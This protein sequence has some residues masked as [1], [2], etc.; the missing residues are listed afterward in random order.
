MIRLSISELFIRGI[1]E[2]MIFMWGI[3]VIS[4]EA[5][6]IKKWLFSSIFIAVLTFIVRMFPI[7]FGVHTV[8]DNVLIVSISVIIGIPLL[9]AIY[10]ILLMSLLLTLCEFLNV[11]L[12]NI[13]STKI[14][15]EGI[16][17]ITKAIIGIPS[18]IGVAL[19]ILLIKFLLQRKEGTKSVSN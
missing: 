12:L 2:M 13:L 5:F 3:Y 6:N 1:P 18:L 11:L 19:L 8:I 9:K 15:F 10:S 14:H 4:K 7:Q 17:P 16:N